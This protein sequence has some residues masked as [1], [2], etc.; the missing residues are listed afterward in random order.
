MKALLSQRG[1]AMDKGDGADI[2]TAFKKT[3]Q[4]I[5]QAVHQDQPSEVYLDKDGNRV[6]LF[7]VSV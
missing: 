2:G 1:A 6:S 3:F 4:G 7:R 5:R